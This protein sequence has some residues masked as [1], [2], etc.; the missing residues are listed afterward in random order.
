MSGFMIGDD[1]EVLIRFKLKNETEEQE[2]QM[3]YSQFKELK[4]NNNL[5]Y[6]RIIRVEST[7]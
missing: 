5:E 7:N 1:D 3:S 4:Q 6:C 2:K